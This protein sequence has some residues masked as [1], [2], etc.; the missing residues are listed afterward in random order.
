MNAQL[1]GETSTS[2]IEVHSRC[3]T[4]YN[5]S[6]IYLAKFSGKFSGIAHSKC[7]QNRNTLRAGH[8]GSESRNIVER[9]VARTFCTKTA[10]GSAGIVMCRFVF[11]VGLH[12]TGQCQRPPFPLPLERSALPS[13]P[14]EEAPRAR[15]PLHPNMSWRSHVRVQH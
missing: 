14:A 5:T 13:T 6:C 4:P 11:G 8:L 15:E 10:C 1:V 7:L 3:R 2:T 9:L 12:L